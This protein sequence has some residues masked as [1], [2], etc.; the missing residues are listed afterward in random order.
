MARFGT[1]R[2]HTLPE[3]NL[4]LISCFFCFASSG[5]PANK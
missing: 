1:D 5:Y 2:F 3:K 4:E